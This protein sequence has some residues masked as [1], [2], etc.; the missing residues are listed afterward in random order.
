MT[1][2]F[3]KIRWKNLLSTGNS[4]TELDLDQDSSTLIVGE[5]GAGKSTL[6]D[7]I[8]FVLYGKAFRKI[9]KPDLINSI[10]QKGLLVEIEFGIGTKSYLVRRGM[11]PN[12]FEIMVD[13]NLLNQDA[14][15]KDYQEVLE[16]NILKLT[17]KSFCQIITLGSST[18]IPFM[19]LPAAGRREF[20]EDLLDIQIFSTMNVLLK[21]KIIDN[22]EDLV[23]CS[24]KIGLTEQRISLNKE[25]IK[26]LKQNNDD[27]VKIKENKISDHQKLIDDCFSKID[28]LELE[29]EQHI[30][31][32]QKEST[33]S[34]KLKTIASLRSGISYKSEECQKHIHFL[35]N[36]DQCPTCA[37]EIESGFKESTLSEKAT[38][39]Q[40]LLEAVE[41]LDREYSE[42]NKEL[43]NISSIQKI[44]S[45]LNAEITDN[46]NKIRMYQKY[47][48][49][50]TKEIQ[51]LKS[52][53]RKI[54]ED[55]VD[56]KTSKKELRDLQKLQ[57]RLTQDR[58]VM[59]NAGLLLKDG[60]IKTKIIKQYVPV[61]NKLIN[62]YLAALDFFVDYNL[63]ENFNEKIKSRHRD[64]FSYSSFSE[65]EKSRIDLALLFTWRA[66]ARIR[67]SASTNL[68]IFDETL[69][70]SLDANGIEE[71]LK[72]LEGVAG[73]TNTFIISHRGD[74]LV[75]KF[76]KIIRFSKVKNFSVMMDQ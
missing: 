65:G 51:D 60:G 10:N 55:S 17:H 44:I 67:N 56:L 24:N 74:S 8:S 61:M 1:V 18:F 23:T 43:E 20:I 64:E 34:T 19:Q 15:S 12:V 16:K 36:N 75:D 42:I 66:I 28:D 57:E 76:S 7:A 3:R 6:L 73:D 2:I 50:L 41:S 26:K 27:L 59:S 71:F 53:Q 52:Q 46:N 63:D 29:I 39:N 38:K 58:T 47:N 62:R 13:G 48:S 25:H 33:L 45:D 4:F 5:N 22:K 21:S 35:E 30:P 14:A 11:K 70:S 9:N 32:T 54:E 49:E 72:I 37:Q 68:L 40:E 31:H 69:D